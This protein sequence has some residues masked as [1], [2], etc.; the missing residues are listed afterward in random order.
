MYTCVPFGVHL[1]TLMPP[2]PP[3]P[4]TPPPPPSPPLTPSSTHP[5]VPPS[6]LAVWHLGSSGVASLCCATSRASGTLPSLTG[7]ARSRCHGFRRVQTTQMMMM[8]LETE[9]PWRE[10]QP[11]GLVVGPTC[12]SC[13]NE[14]LRLSLCRRCCSARRTRTTAAWIRCIVT[15]CTRVTLLTHKV[16]LTAS[17]AASICLCHHINCTRL[18]WKPRMVDRY[19]HGL[20]PIMSHICQ[21]ISIPCLSDRTG[22]V[23]RT[24][25]YTR[26][27][28]D[29]L[30]HMHAPH[31]CTRAEL[32]HMA[33][34][35]EM[36]CCCGR[37]ERRTALTHTRIDPS[38]AMTPRQCEPVSY[39]QAPHCLLCITT[40]VAHL[41]EL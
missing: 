12:H 28:D 3:P 29:R 30:H 39:I 1:P 17:G 16:A 34:W 15:L 41:S 11:A 27:W 2:P 35:Q 18:I 6:T 25:A 4:L 33:R 32:S 37:H 8:A 20:P 13:T 36:L 21:H 31:A 19:C 14:C 26:D 9:M 23:T 24:P 22:N 5:A 10:L 7:R 40:H 38:A